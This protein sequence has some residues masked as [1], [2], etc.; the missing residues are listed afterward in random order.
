MALTPTTL[1][2]LLDDLDESASSLPATHASLHTADPGATGT[3]E[4]TGGTPAYARKALTWSAASGTTK[5]AAQVTFDVPAGTTVT[6]F[7]LWSA[8]TSGT[9]RG[10]AA[11][12]ASNVFGAQG[13]LLV[14]ITLTAT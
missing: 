2:T 5:A 13:T 4:V 12:S 9:F 10:G 11:L 7:G 6:H 8:S 14:T 3:S 1:N